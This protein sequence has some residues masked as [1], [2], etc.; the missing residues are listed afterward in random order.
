MSQPVPYGGFKWV[1]DPDGIKVSDYTGDSGRGMVLKV[2]MEYPKKLHRKHN[3]YPFAPESKI[4]T[5]D[6][7]S[8]YAR[9]IAEK[10]N[11]SVG[12][13]KKLVTTLGPRK[14]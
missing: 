3:G 8:D 4:I 1:D 14:K 7:L 6:M 10:F 2:D 5:P 9:K 13:V 12:G 11:I